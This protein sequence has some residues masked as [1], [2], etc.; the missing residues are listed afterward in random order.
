MKSSQ[1]R[2]DA[3]FSGGLLPGD[4][5]AAAPN[6]VVQTSAHVVV[7]QRQDAERP[8]FIHLATIPPIMLGFK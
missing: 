4:R 8:L 1:L 5:M 6:E 2:R 3:Q 7:E